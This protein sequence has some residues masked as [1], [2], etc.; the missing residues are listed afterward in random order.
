MTNATLRGATATLP[1][2]AELQPLQ[3]RMAAQ[4]TTLQVLSS[5]LS[6]LG[7]TPLS[8]GAAAKLTQAAEGLPPEQKRAFAAALNTAL[9]AEQERMKALIHGIR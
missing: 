9:A 3:E 2:Q 4:N 8:Q 7:S 6:A 1:R 5:L